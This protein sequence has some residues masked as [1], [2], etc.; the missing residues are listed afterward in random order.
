MNYDEMMEELILNYHETASEDPELFNPE[1][2]EDHLNSMD[3]EQLTEE[4]N[5]YFGDN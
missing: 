3:D 5:N 4:Y 2:Y 1:W